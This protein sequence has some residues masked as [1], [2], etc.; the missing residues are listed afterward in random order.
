MTDIPATPIVTDTPPASHPPFKIGQRVQVVNLINGVPGP[1][2]GCAGIIRQLFRVEGEPAA[3]VV[4][5]TSI[6]NVEKNILQFKLRPLAAP[7]AFPSTRTESRR[8]LPD[9]APKK[10]AWTLGKELQPS[11]KVYFSKIANPRILH[12]RIK[13][14]HWQTTVVA[15]YYGRIINVNQFAEIDE[16]RWYVTVR[17][18]R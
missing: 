9:W 6:G 12:E 13:P 8:P 14:G 5:R 17:A 2:H 11:D 7:P 1:Y 15:E 16:T 18:V 4:F 10:A 3:T